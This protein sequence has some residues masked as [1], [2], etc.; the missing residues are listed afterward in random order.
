MIRFQFFSCTSKSITFVACFEDM[1]L[2]RESIQ[3][4]T[5]QAGTAEHFDPLVKRQVGCDDDTGSFIG[6]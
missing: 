2:M 6:G 1:A 4:S 5:G 3:N